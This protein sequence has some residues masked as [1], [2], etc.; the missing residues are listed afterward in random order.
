MK[1]LDLL[2]EW[3]NSSEIWRNLV[4]WHFPYSRESTELYI[5][6]IDNNNMQYQNFGIE[7]K[8]IGLIGTTNLVDID[9]KNKHASNGIMLGNIETRGKG[10]ALDA[11][12]AIMEYAF[13]ELG[14]NR[15]DAEMI[16]YNNRSIDFYTE[17]C[18][19]KAEGTRSEWI[20]RNGQYHDKVLCGITH[21]QYDAH[22]AKTNYW[23]K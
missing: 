16:D 14:L 5:K 18:G 13:K 12:M 10:Y 23:N 2:A 17:K 3:A 19:W 15:L 21:E 1:D 11:V 6:S 20:Y 8:D 22:I 4:G 7:V 9:W